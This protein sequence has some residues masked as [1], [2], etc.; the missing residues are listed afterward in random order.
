[1]ISEAEKLLEELRTKEPKADIFSFNTLIKV[2]CND[3]KFDDAK[4]L[5]DELLKDGL[6]ENRWTY[7]AL[8][9]VLCEKG[10]FDFALELCKKSLGLSCYL[11]AGILQV[12]V[13]GL[14]KQSKVDD[15]NQLVEL[16]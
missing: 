12:V 3:G 1:K 9:P 16:A 4:R 15:A 14:V 6:K 10:D 13:D 11:S 8:I 5:Y 2:Y 7:E